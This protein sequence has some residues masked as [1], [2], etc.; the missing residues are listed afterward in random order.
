MKKLLLITS[1]LISS[2][3]YALTEI[4]HADK[5]QETAA[6]ENTLKDN[7][8]TLLYVYADWCEYCKKDMVKATAAKYKNINFIA[9][10]NDTIKENKA[11]SEMLSNVLKEV[12]HKGNMG[13]PTYFFIGK[14]KTIKKSGGMDEKA[15]DAL[16]EEF[17]KGKL[18]TDEE[19]HAE[20]DKLVRENP[21]P[22]KE[23][24]IKNIDKDEELANPKEK[25]DPV[26]TAVIDN[27]ELAAAKKTAPVRRKAPRKIINK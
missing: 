14:G 19:I 12:G 3:V 15:F 23:E 21:A 6:L 4:K 27:E 18:K 5:A 10:N 9:I 16:V 20:Y 25:S 1:L 13:L 7:R 24:K 26:K 17:S 11:L 8:P 2:G 22:E